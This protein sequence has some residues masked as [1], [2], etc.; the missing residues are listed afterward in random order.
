VQIGEGIDQRH[1]DTAVEF[2]P[3]GEFRWDVV[4]DHK[5]VAPLVHDK[6]RADDAF[7][8]A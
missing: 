3:A 1:A 7:V 4:A 8:L 2:G 5:A 6:D